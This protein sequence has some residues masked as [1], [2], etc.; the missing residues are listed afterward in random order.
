VSA[1]NFNETANS[2][3]RI[4]PPEAEFNYPLKYI[5]SITT[6]YE[7]QRSKKVNSNSI[8]KVG[9]LTKLYNSNQ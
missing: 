1:E 3:F 8:L 6:S 7:K 4:K 5:K 2:L 9:L